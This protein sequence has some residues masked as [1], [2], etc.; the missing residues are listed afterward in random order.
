MR[1]FVILLC[2][3]SLIS[4]GGGSSDT[5]TVTVPPVN[6]SPD[7]LP[8]SSD[9]NHATPAEVG[10]DEAVISGVYTQAASQNGLRSLLVLKNGQLVAEQYFN[11]QTAQQLQH[12]RSVTKT[13]TALLTGIAI[14][15][16][17]LSM[18]ATLGEFFS[19][20]Y[21]FAD[22]RAQ[23]VTV[24][25]L[26]TMTSGYD[27]DESGAALY[28]EWAQSNE[29]VEFLLSRNLTSNPG[30]TF[31]YNSATVHLLGV[32]ISTVSETSL[33]QFAQ[34]RLF[35]PLGIN[36]IRW[37]ILADG[38][39]N[40]SAGLELRPIDQA[41]LGLLIQNNGLYT[42]PDGS[43][44]QV[45]PE[46]WVTALKQEQVELTGTYSALNYRG[47]G[48]LNWLG[49]SAVLSDSTANYELAWGWGGQFILTHP[50]SDLILVT[51][52]DWSV[53]ASQ[54]SQQ[55]QAMLAILIDGLLNA[56][57]N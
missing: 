11:G 19:G 3:L 33:Q 9:I 41:K 40:G 2:C 46:S 1:L 35:E 27:W 30:E 22:A 5:T 47:Y 6:N 7:Y 53:G 13:V 49:E 38:R 39:H 4:C 57:A 37:E 48:Y 21:S 28:V 25:Q 23:S 16:G 52:S 43:A 44:A 56:T 12:V 51:N 42:A 17:I 55:Q 18:Q 54:A 32:I 31:T 45:V 34:S 29:P 14:D 10:I 20:D 50:A 24:E 8:V 26:L 36:A 15:E